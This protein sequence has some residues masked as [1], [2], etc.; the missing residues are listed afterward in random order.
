MQSI[1]TAI[2]EAGLPEH[3][4]SHAT[5]HSYAVHLLDKTGNLAYVQQQLGHSNIATTSIYL[6]VLPDKNG[7]LANMIDADENFDE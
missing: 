6:S 3:Y 5:R 2:R 4:S 1:K 7:I